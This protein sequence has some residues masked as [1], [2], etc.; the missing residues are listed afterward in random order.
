MSKEKMEA[1]SRLA[2]HLG[3]DTNN[4][5]NAIDGYAALIEDDLSADHPARE[6]ATRI[7]STVARGFQ[8]TAA[9]LQFARPFPRA[10]I[11]QD[12]SEVLLSLIQELDSAAVTYDAPETPV[13]V[14]L[15]AEDLRELVEA[16]IQNAFEAEASQ[17][18]LTLSS[19]SDGA[20]LTV[21]DDGTGMS[22]DMLAHAIEPLAKGATSQG[23]G[24]GLSIVEGALRSIG[25]SLSLASSPKG[26]TITLT[27]PS[28]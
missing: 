27:F 19:E 5:L 24:L 13:M 1:L 12:L 14:M 16:L 18:A 2:R 11:A 15:N 25:G 21:T 20:T 23:S 8:D 7:R 4:L 22:D 3:H 17:V 6:F 10:S 26:T 28:L 9:I